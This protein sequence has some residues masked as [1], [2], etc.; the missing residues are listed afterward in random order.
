MARFQIRGLNQA[1]AAG[2]LLALGLLLAGVGAG[3]LPWVWRAPV[4]QQLTAPGLAEFVKF[5]PEVRLG[6]LQTERLY[7]LLP[8]WVAA[9]VLP[10]ISA[11]QK[12]ALPAWFRWLLR[13]AVLPLALAG[14]SPVWTPAILLAPEFRLQTLLALLAIALALAAP[15]LHKL[16][17]LALLILLA[18]G[19][20]PGL[21]LAWW[22]FSLMQ[23]AIAAAYHEPVSLGWG[24]WVTVAGVVLS[25]IGAAWRVSLPHPLPLPK[26]AREAGQESPHPG[27]EG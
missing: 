18:G 3:F 5:L 25:I 20:L 13:L 4:A 9:L 22:Q 15:L 19:S 16:P 11:N 23:S 10:F 26:R 14:L 27:G 17:P 6:Q 12:L 7:F 2:G 1:G 24:W 21:S 8:L